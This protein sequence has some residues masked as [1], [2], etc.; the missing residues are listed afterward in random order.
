MKSDHGSRCFLFTGFYSVTV[1]AF[2]FPS[3]SF[4]FAESPAFHGDAVSY[5]KSGIKAN[6]ELSD[7]IYVFIFLVGVVF[8]LKGSAFCNGSEIGLQF[9]LS[10]AAAIVL[11]G[12]GTGFFIWSDPDLIIIMLKTY[13]VIRKRAEV[14]LIYRVTCVG[15]KLS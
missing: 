4:F 14:E 3:A 10:H 2:R 15:D 8:K 6:A 5:H 1:C 13:T 9:F 7:D 12:E 11:Y